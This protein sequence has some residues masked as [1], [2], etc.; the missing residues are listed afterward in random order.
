MPITKLQFRPGI[1]Q[2]VTSYS[3]EGGWVDGDKIRFRFGYPEKFG[4]W[5]KMSGNTYEGT[6]RRLHNWLALD[7]SNYLG[8]GTHLKYYIEEGGL[9][10]DITPTRL[11]TSL[12]DVT[13]SATNG[14]STITVNENN[15]GAS[16][17]DFVTFSGVATLGGL[18]TASI[19]NAE[20]KI[21]SILNGNSYTI[22]VSVTANSSDTGNG[23]FTDA[24]CDYNNDP[25]ITMDSTATLAVGG[26]VSGT[27]IPT[28]AT[29]ASITDATNFELSASTTG[30]SVTNG[31]LTF[32][33]S[34]AV[35]QINTGL[36]SQ[37]GGTGWGA[38]LWGGITDNALT[39]QLN[40]AV[41][42]SETAIDVDD[43][44]GITTD[45]DVIF[46]DKT[47]SDVSTTLS[48]AVSSAGAT[49]IAVTSA[50]GLAAGDTIVIGSEFVKIGGISTND[51]TGCTR[52]HLNSTATT[53]LDKT[54][55]VLVDG[56]ELMTVTAT[57][58]DNTLTVTRGA[59]GTIA[60]AH[61]N[62][63]IVRLAVGNVS[64][65]D[66]FTGWGIA[67]VTGTTREI[68]TWSHDNF[69]EDLFINPRDEAVYRWDKTNGLTT[70]AVEISTIS[71]AE[72][73]PTVAKQIMV[74]ENHLIAFGTNI[75]GTTTQ[76]PLL[77]RFSDDENQLLFTV[78]SGSAASFLTIGSGSEFI[79]AIKTKREILV[80]T[81]I[82]LHSLR[83]IGYPNYYRIDQ[84]TSSITI[85]GSKAAVAVED[86]V[87][88]MGKD[89]FYVYAGGTQT[90]PCTVKD[91]VFLDFNNNQ[92]DKVV[93]GV[94]SEYTEVIWFYPSES[95]SLN[96]GGTGDVDKY[97]IYNY[98]QKIWYYGTL[99]RTAW[100][101]RGIR[102][103]PIAASDV[104][105]NS[106]AELT[107]G[108]AT[109]TIDSTSALVVNSLVSGNGIPEGSR[110]I[111]IT[112][113]TTFE[114][115]NN[116]TTTQT[117]VTLRFN[118]SNTH[119]LFNHETGYNDD[120][121]AMTS[122]I[123]SAPMDIGDGDKFS[124]VQKVIPDLSFQGS[125]SQSSPAANFTLK[126]RNEPGENYGN[127][128]A[129][130]ATRISTSP[131]ETFTNQLN[132]RARGRS[133][134][135]R[136]DSDALGVRWKLGSPRVS[137]RPDGRR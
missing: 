10:N 89:S 130:T 56:A 30:G 22:T 128:S 102:N 127:T 49:T 74:D 46:I 133:F 123:E 118:N 77:I 62:D 84:I 70:R 99:S 96:N 29:V 75:Y 83:Y 47:P 106:S 26:T 36:N 111:S 114:L 113:A 85:M 66:D 2:E 80:W 43:E 53:H 31:T 13:F 67:A 122:F 109:V 68:R 39:T 50:S 117:G 61:A 42:N 52:G 98:G 81:D 76:D 72:N 1:N 54:S 132:L 60:S 135:L 8:I 57:S 137:I 108:D 27:G 58:D 95:N 4:G 21:V 59:S 103:F 120:T 94:N 16:E 69:G 131:V 86:A 38:G 97:V 92:S 35:Y 134:A 125:T 90:L 121:I 129:G 100:I 101:D 78:R 34:K 7:N 65:D 28:G 88:W 44:T 91:K 23:S 40:E 45:N 116:A 6:A 51:L 119:H 20:H 79:Q 19:L 17:N 110:I 41:D 107:N 87:F 105:I 63:T 136:V 15:H 93:A 73:A 37:V 12:G 71:G 104:L 124:L 82:S 25:T 9:F 33:N 126:A 5:E 115:S 64:S 3:N 18:V 11:T 24:T 55:V 112:N 32:N 14:S 48:A